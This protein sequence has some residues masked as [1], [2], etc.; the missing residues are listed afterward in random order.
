MPVDDAYIKAEEFRARIGKSV[1]ADDG[2]LDAILK[3]VSRLLDRECGGEEEPRF[4]N[5]DA[6]LT[7]RHYDGNGLARLYITDVATTSDLVVKA[8]L[9]GDHDFDGTDET[10]TQGTHFWIG[11]W[12]APLGSEA[13]PYRFLEVIPNNGRLSVWPERLRAIQVTAIFG[14][15]AVPEAIKDAVAMITHEITGLEHAGPTAA[16]QN[17]DNAVNLSPTAFSIVQRIKREYGLISLFV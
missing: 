9:D 4:F 14:W 13:R 8:D 2:V 12:N 6:E 5:Q 11:P 10:L 7:I 15:P 17:V 3:G 16:L 1:T